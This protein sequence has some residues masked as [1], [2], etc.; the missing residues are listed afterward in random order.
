MTRPGSKP[1]P[2]VV[3]RPGSKSSPAHKNLLMLYLEAIQLVTRLLTEG[4]V[5]DSPSITAMAKTMRRCL[6]EASDP[7]PNPNPKPNPNPNPNPNPDRRPSR[8]ILSPRP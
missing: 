2:A 1:S 4:R 7:N 6:V 5:S 8:L 3:T